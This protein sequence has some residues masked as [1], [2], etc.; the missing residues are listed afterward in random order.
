MIPVR[1]RKQGSLVISPDDESK[2]KEELFG[3]IG[4]ANSSGPFVVDPKSLLE[5]LE[6]SEGVARVFCKRCDVTI[7]VTMSLAKKLAQKAK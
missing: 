5:P 7:E 6:W 3:R 4:V 2:M 1:I